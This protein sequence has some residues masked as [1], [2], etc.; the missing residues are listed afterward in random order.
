MKP[1]ASKK[2]IID[3]LFPIILF[4]VLAVSAC[5]VIALSVKIYENTVEH[6]YRNHQ[7]RIA[8]S[9][10]S[11]K[12]HQTDSS[13]MIELESWETGNVLTIRQI[14]HDD[15]YYTYL[16]FYDHTLRELFV[17]EGVTFSLSDGKEIL[18]LKDFSIEI[19]DKGLLYAACTDYEGQTSDSYISIAQN[20]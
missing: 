19:A 12:L 18:D 13:S 6:S 15:T 5:M 3:L 10:I 9:Y 17:R 1:T 2:H 14:Y 11:E 4:M 16:Y 7:A 20:D 8:L